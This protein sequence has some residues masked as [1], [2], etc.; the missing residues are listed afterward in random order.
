MG[1]VS[2]LAYGCGYVGLDP[3][4]DD[5]LLEKNGDDSNASGGASSTGGAGWGGMD[6]GGSVGEPSTGGESA[7][8]PIL[9]CTFNCPEP[10][11]IYRAFELGVP[12]TTSTTLGGV[13]QRSTEEAYRGT[14]SMEFM[15]GGPAGEAEITESIGMRLSDGLHLRAWVF[16]P[17][18][19]VT[20]SFKIVAF[21]G[22]ATPGIDV[23]I[24]A[25][26]A[27][28]AYSYGSSDSAISEENRAIFGEWFCLQV[29]AELSETAGSVTVLVNEKLAI[30]LAP[31]D[32]LPPDAISR[33][34]YGLAATSMEQ[35]G[36][37]VYFDELVISTELVGCNEV[38]Q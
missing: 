26:G 20:D 24:H 36:A 25:N 15:Q 22:G 7:T 17:H 6:G 14:H 30:T 37:S 3:S 12:V 27:V 28:E 34:V 31:T 19:A 4:V 38:A 21:N 5:H 11:L 2:S 9:P 23:S 10:Y 32:T 18:G 13:V 29:G 8:L 1:V 33:V 35:M 16:I